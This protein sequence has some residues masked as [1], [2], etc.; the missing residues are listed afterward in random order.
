[1]KQVIRLTESDLHRIIKESVVRIIKEN[2]ENGSYN[3][4]YVDSAIKAGIPANWI[5]QKIDEL[6]EKGYS[7]KEIQ[8]SLDNFAYEQLNDFK[9]KY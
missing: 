6:F 4:V 8:Q 9:Y 1:M 5:Y 3:G 2:A 7:A